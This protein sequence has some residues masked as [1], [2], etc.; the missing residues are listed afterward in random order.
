MKNQSESENLS[1]LDK[2]KKLLEEQGKT[3]IDV[4]KGDDEPKVDALNTIICSAD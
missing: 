3:I 4:V 2:L 1:S